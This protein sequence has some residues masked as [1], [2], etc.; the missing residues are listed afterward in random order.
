MLFRNYSNRN[1]SNIV[2]CHDLFMRAAYGIAPISLLRSRPLQAMRSRRAAHECMNDRVPLNQHL[3]RTQ[4]PHSA[5]LVVAGRGPSQRQDLATAVGSEL[6]LVRFSPGHSPEQ[7]QD[8]ALCTCGG[9]DGAEVPVVIVVPEDAAPGPGQPHLHSPL[10]EPCQRPAQ[11]G[12]PLLCMR[13][14]ARSSAAVS[15][16]HYFVASALS[17]EN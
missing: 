16:Q 6:G 5:C 13:H 3:Q 4:Q 15:A 8:K 12:T 17:A 10:E 7:V 11:P 2:P 1:L 14:T 9:A